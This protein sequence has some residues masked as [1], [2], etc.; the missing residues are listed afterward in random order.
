MH[1]QELLAKGPLRAG[2]LPRDVVTVLPHGAGC[3]PR[4]GGGNGG[5]GGLVG[6]RDPGGALCNPDAAPRASL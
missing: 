5:P 3:S 1:S 6:R 4:L 2:V